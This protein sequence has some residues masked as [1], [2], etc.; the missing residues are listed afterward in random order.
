[1][2]PW[3]KAWPADR[4]TGTVVNFGQSSG[5]FNDFQIKDLAAGSLY[6]TR[7]TLFH[8][9]TERDWLEAASADMF[10]TR[11]PTAR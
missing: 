11:S 3:R 9:A 10:A 7:P 2:T 5:P 8:F 1:M 4:R 6:L